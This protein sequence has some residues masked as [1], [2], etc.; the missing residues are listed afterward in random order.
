[1]DIFIFIFIFGWTNFH[2]KD[3]ND[4]DIVLKTF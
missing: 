2:T 1:M 3:N 4:T